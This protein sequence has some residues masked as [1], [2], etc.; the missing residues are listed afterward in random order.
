MRDLAAIRVNASGHG[1]ARRLVA[2]ASPRENRA[3]LNSTWAM[4]KSPA[5]S[6]SHRL[7]QAVAFFV[8]RRQR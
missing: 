1:V 5:A 6:I 2:P 7:C 4:L 8:D 3:R